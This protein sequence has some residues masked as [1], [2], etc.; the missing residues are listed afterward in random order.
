MEPAMPAIV[1]VTSAGDGEGGRDVGG[2]PLPPPPQAR[3][4][5]A[6]AKITKPNA[7]RRAIF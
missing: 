3:V 6:R 1:M 7:V 4:P 5:T 2:D